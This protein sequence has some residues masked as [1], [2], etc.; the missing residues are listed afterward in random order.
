MEL[1]GTAIS[2]VSITTSVVAGCTTLDSGWVKLFPESTPAQVVV[3]R[4]V[5][6][7]DGGESMTIEKVQCFNT[8]ALLRDGKR[9][10]ELDLEDLEEVTVSD[11]RDDHGRYIKVFVESVPSSVPAGSLPSAFDSMATAAARQVSVLPAKAG[12]D[13]YWMRIMNSLISSCE[14]ASSKSAVT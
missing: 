9:G 1:S 5:V 10:K 6:R 13:M 2:K 4:A 3:D 14:K 12:D 7:L 11:L 8:E